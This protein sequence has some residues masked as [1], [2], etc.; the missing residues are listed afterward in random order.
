MLTI[1]LIIKTSDHKHDTCFYTVEL[2][3]FKSLSKH[4]S[5]IIVLYEASQECVWLH[6]LIEDNAACVAQMQ[7]GYI[8]SSYM[9]HISPKLF[10]PQQLQ[11]SGD[12]KD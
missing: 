1:Y 4:H 8:K 3:Y 11:E 10:Y 9:K 12:L 5:E 2:L 6:R 7:T